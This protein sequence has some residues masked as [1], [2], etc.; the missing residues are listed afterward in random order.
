MLTTA[1][2]LLRTKLF[3]LLKDK[4]G[5]S[6]TNKNKQINFEEIDDWKR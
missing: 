6:M 5:C 3:D 4:K 2:E 1:S